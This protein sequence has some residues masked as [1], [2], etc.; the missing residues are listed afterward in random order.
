MRGLVGSGVGGCDRNSTPTRLRITTLCQSVKMPKIITNS[1][2]KTAA[3]K[4]GT[5]E[6]LRRYCESWCATNFRTEIVISEWPSPKRRR[7][8]C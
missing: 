5:P 2:K 6:G 1:P 8:A 3:C 4:T 7:I